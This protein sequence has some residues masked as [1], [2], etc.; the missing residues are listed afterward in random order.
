[1]I[2]GTMAPGTAGL[3][4][5]LVGAAGLI[6]LLSLLSAFWR[7]V[8][9]ILIVSFL[10]FGAGKVVPEQRAAV[11]LRVQNLVA[12]WTATMRKWMDE[13]GTSLPGAQGAPEQPAPRSR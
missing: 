3:L 2:E 12:S 7:T 1:V 13:V 9:V 11:E 4:L 6:L 5:I 8:Q 10:W